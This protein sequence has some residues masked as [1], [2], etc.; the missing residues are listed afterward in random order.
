LRPAGG[1]KDAHRYGASLHIKVLWFRPM[2]DRWTIVKEYAM[3]SQVMQQPQHRQDAST[4]EVLKKHLRRRLSTRIRGLAIAVRA[5]G[6]VLKGQVRSFYEKQ[7]AQQ[8]LM[9]ATNTPIAFN[10]LEV[11]AHQ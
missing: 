10:Q 7:L 5:D 8:A 4:V 3:S 6:L 11:D 1:I 2:P 9:E